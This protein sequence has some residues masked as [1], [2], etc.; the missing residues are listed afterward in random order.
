MQQFQKETKFVFKKLSDRFIKDVCHCRFYPASRFKVRCNLGPFFFFFSLSTGL[1]D[2]TS[3][4]LQET[5]SHHDLVGQEFTP[6]FPKK[7]KEK[8]EKK[9]KKEINHITLAMATLM[10]EQQ[11]KYSWCV[12]QMEISKH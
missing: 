10:K 12:F 6:N 11:F 8:K 4:L 5:H 7:R 2:I 9:L 3:Q 1:S